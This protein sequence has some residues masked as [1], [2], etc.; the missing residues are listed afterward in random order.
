MDAEIT[1]KIRINDLY[2]KDDLNGMNF[3][4]LVQWLVD[5]S[6]ITELIDLADKIEIVDVKKI[7][8]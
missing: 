4:E 3:K 5:E 7:Y 2:V 8:A 6:C 1:F